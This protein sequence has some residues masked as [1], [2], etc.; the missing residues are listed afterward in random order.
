MQNA[1]KQAQPETEEEIITRTKPVKG[2]SDVDK[3]IDEYKAEAHRRDTTPKCTVYKY[4]DEKSGQDRVFAGY[5][6]GDE[7]PNRHTIGL[8]YG[9][10][11]YFIQLE[12][13][14]GSAEEGEETT[15][16][17]RIH[18]IYDQLKAKADAEKYRKESAEMQA[19]GNGGQMVQV[20]AAQSFGMVK[21]ILS[22][23]LP[24]LKAQNQA[25]AAP[26][27][28]QET[29]ADM[30]NAYTMMQK[31]LKNNLFDTAA[32]YREFNRRFTSQDEIE[33]QDTQSIEEQKQKEGG[34]LLEKII[35][36][37]EPFFAMIADKSPAGRIAAQGLRSAPQFLDVLNDPQLCRMIIQHFDKTKGRAKSDIALQNIG[38]DRNQLFKTPPPTQRK[39]ATIPAQPPEA[40]EAPAHN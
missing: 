6:T 11:R 9:S 16:L 12:Q 5:F 26:A 36:L 29:P 14:K 28:R 19:S 35:S 30:L 32:T 7:L 10:G 1:K 24:V 34:S 31:L 23:I 21:D 25:A 8:L 27:P 2:R 39:P 4:T 38:I 20:Q 17:F 22:L 3:I 40:P 37:I 18:A 33:D 13:P 15:L